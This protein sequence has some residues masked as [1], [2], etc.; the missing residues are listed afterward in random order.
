LY[1]NCQRQNCK[2]FICLTIRAKMIGGDDPF[3]LKLWVKLR[4]IADFRSI[5]VRRASAVTPG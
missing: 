5:F 3:Y 1:E 4:E 2:A